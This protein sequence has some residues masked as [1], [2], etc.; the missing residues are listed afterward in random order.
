[1]S[2]SEALFPTAAV[3]SSGTLIDGS[4]SKGEARFI[5]IQRKSHGR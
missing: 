5:K 3:P 2:D 4:G 1:M